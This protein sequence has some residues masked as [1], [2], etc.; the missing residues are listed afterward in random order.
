MIEI[1]FEPASTVPDYHTESAPNDSS[2]LGNGPNSG[3]DILRSWDKMSTIPTYDAGKKTL[4]IW[5]SGQFDALRE[6]HV[7]SGDFSSKNPIE[8]RHAI[9]DLFYVHTRKDR[10]KLRIWNGVQRRVEDPAIFP[11]MF[12]ESRHF[13]KQSNTPD[14]SG[15]PQC[16]SIF[17]TKASN[18][19]ILS[20]KPTLH[21]ITDSRGI[22]HEVVCQKR[23]QNFV[24]YNRPPA[25]RK[26]GRR[27]AQEMMNERKACD[28]WELVYSQAGAISGF[29]VDSSGSGRFLHMI[30]GVKVVCACPPSPRNWLIFQRYY[31][32]MPDVR[33]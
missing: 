20:C 10:P 25:L 12:V 28:D 14:G 6:G 22:S 30:S 23:N 31:K 1:S 24:E 26:S 32:N 27:A 7:D 17:G 29:H 3:V 2:H 5:L 21:K 13:K 8:P 15:K 19:G 16:L 4:H 33:E 18:R 9:D 11:R